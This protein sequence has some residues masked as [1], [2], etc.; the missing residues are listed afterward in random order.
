MLAVNYTNLRD[1]MKSYMDKVTD[2]YETVVVTR[3][4]NKNVVMLSEESYNN[5]VENIYVM[6]NKSNYDWLMESK[7]QLEKGNVSTHDLVEE[8]T[9]E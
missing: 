8:E 9:Y 6:G 2:D 4:D 7:A 1:N 5:L 3:K